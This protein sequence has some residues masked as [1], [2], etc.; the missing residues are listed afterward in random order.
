MLFGGVRAIWDSVLRISIITA[1]KVV[2][3][4]EGRLVGPWVNE[5]RDTVWRTDGWRDP[6][7]IDVADLTFADDEGEN[8]LCCLHRLGA[9]F[10]GRGLFSGYLLDRLNIPLNETAFERSDEKCRR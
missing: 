1:D 8:A 2:L 9:R 7:E 10:H 5:L 4:L 6:M 3:K